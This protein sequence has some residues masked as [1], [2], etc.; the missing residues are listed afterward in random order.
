MLAVLTQRLQMAFL[1]YDAEAGAV[2]TLATGD[3]SDVVGAALE[4]GPMMA[5]SDV[6]GL[7]A[8]HMYTSV[9]KVVPTQAAFSEQAYNLRLSELLV[10]DMCFV[11]APGQPMLAVLAQ[12]ATGGRIVRT[13][14]IDPE[15]Q[16][17]VDGPWDT[18][19]VDGSASMLV[20]CQAGE[21]AGVL[22]VG[23]ETTALVHAVGVSEVAHSAWQPSAWCPAAGHTDRALIG[24]V[25]GEARVFGWTNEF[26]LHVCH[27]GRTSAAAT[28]AHLNDTVVFV[29]SA[30]DDS[31]LVSVPALGVG[32]PADLAMQGESVQELERFASLA[33]VMDMCMLESSV[34]A[35]N[36]LITASGAYTGGS[37]RRIRHGISV[38]VQAEIG[39]EGLRS[40]WPVTQPAA[41]G[42]AVPQA[43]ATTSHLILS[44]LGNTQV[45]A[46]NDDEIEEVEPAAMDLGH[47][48]LAFGACGELWVQVTAQQVRAFRVGS[49]DDFTL[50][51]SWSPEE[52]GVS[53]SAAAVCSLGVVVSYGSG[54]VQV[55]QASPAAFVPAA[56]VQ[57]ENDVS[58]LSVYEHAA[59][60]LLLVGQWTSQAVHMYNLADMS[61]VARVRIPGHV[62]ASSAQVVLQSAGAGHLVV[63]TGEG[64]LFQYP[65]DLAAEQQDRLLD[66]SKLTS[67]HVSTQPVSLCPLRV[68]Q[69]DCVFVACDSPCLLHYASGSLSCTAVN[70][71]AARDIASFNTAAFPGCIAA[72][73][74]AGLCLGLLD[75]T[76]RIK[77]QTQAL[78]AQPRAVAHHV[79][80]ATLCVATV[81]E[82]ASAE[83]VAASA[84]VRLHDLSTLA[85]LD[86]Y[87]LDEFEHPQCVASMSLLPYLPNFEQQSGRDAQPIAGAEPVEYLVVGTAY[88]L[89]GEEEPSSGRVLVFAV[90]DDTSAGAITKKLR[91]VTAYAPG[92]GVF[93]VTGCAGAVAI[94]VT[95]SVELCRLCV[96]DADAAD[97]AVA[98][99]VATPLHE[100]TLRYVANYGMILTVVSLHSRGNFLLVGDLMKSLS[101]L[102]WRPDIC[103]L[104][105]VAC[106][107]AVQWTTAAAFV[108]DDHFF[109]AD[110]NYNLSILGRPPHTVSAIDRGRMNTMAEFNLGE[111]VNAALRGAL[112]PAGLQ[113]DFTQAGSSPASPSPEAAHGG[114]TK[115][116]RTETGEVKTV[117]QPAP[118]RTSSLLMATVNGSMYSMFTLPKAAYQ[119]LARLQTAILHETASVGGFPY[120]QWRG[121]WA[122]AAPAYQMSPSEEGIVSSVVDGDVIERFLDYPAEQQASIVHYMKTSKAPST[123]H[124][125]RSLNPTGSA[126]PASMSEII[127]FILHCARRH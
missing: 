71:G 27:C 96:N 74:S 4:Q 101:L 55:L 33:P 18:Q 72:V 118:V 23:C 20:P 7:V 29:G 44:T 97:T 112:V 17:L 57:E 70:I 63:G 48:T 89:E 81:G 106:D 111:Q 12:N 61:R 78:A 60:A 3:V 28:L 47:G 109:L 42:A 86:S 14:L 66:A 115:R 91:L 88:V 103:S 77:V 36:S 49:G 80:S 21:Q 95:G 11:P 10:L 94:G 37:L 127:A 46:V 15:S 107:P 75:S 54:R 105:E 56:T 122:S 67:I 58:C 120:E 53:I 119:F 113:T 125:E 16:T 117:P 102:V 121:Y 62:Q 108:D 93:A 5:C 26:E 85:E 41:D 52:A 22:V 98:A 68:Q 92:G 50:A 25:G 126:E 123:F 73:D 9:I 84:H 31:Q 99:G 24:G 90:E 83:E 76:Q 40:I 19:N 69:K 34:G 30:C 38:S 124:P 35:T 43:E 2:T 65:L 6:H 104:D 82:S 32:Q 8:L 13:F 1:V 110:A 64:M 45:L 116:A 87:A 100:A 59:G 79:T 51:A 114:V 39:M